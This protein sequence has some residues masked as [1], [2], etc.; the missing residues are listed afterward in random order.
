M[1]LGAVRVVATAGFTL[2]PLP[3]PFR[4]GVPVARRRTRVVPGGRVD[5]VTFIQGFN[6]FDLAVL[7]I[8]AV[9]F[10][11]GFMQ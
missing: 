5:I 7:L 3:S 2:L 10:V 11:I 1:R 4:L 8:L 9:S 6:L